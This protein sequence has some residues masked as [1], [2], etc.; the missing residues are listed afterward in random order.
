MS[1]LFYII[2]NFAWVAGNILVAYIAVAIVVFVLA[3]YILFDPKATTAGK[4]LFRFMVSL[5]GVI[6]L[7]FIGT[8][9]DPSPNR[10][11][12]FLSLEV[13]GWRPIVRFAIY[14]YVAFTITSLA[15]LLAVRKWKPHR[16]RSSDD[17]NLIEVRS[18]KD[19]SVNQYE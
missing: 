4:F 15:I 17:R 6:V 10:D 12:S 19:V 16:L 1:D 18:T 14:S 5:V 13:A 2:N 11:W 9:I 7:V 3:Y 8:Y